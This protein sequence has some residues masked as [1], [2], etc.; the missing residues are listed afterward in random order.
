MGIMLFLVLP[1]VAGKIGIDVTV[2]KPFSASGSWPVVN[3]S[4][5]KNASNPPLYFSSGITLRPGISTGFES[6]EEFSEQLRKTHSFYGIF[7]GTHVGFSPA[8][9]PGI[10][11]GVSF[12]REEIFGVSGNQ[13]I[14]TGY[15][16]FKICPLFGISLQFFILSFLITN[17]GIGG[18]VNYSFGR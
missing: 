6:N 16:P 11:A 7:A 2:Q 18:G 12:K 5:L 1:C 14:R 4:F 8:V 9:R 15:T 3:V 17:E 13:Q 10:V